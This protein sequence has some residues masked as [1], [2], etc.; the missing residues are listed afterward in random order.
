[1]CVC[2]CTGA[3][4]TEL[5]DVDARILCTLTMHLKMHDKRRV[6]M[7]VQEGRGR[8]AGGGRGKYCQR[9]GAGR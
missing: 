6:R 4:V 7:H 5:I 3:G 2:T 1:M 9:R 8:P